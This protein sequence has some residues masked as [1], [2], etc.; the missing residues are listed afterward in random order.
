MTAGAR[1]IAGRFVYSPIDDFP[2]ARVQVGAVL[3]RFSNRIA[4]KLVFVYH[5]VG[6]DRSLSG[7]LAIAPR[8]CYRSQRHCADGQ[9]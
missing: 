9:G 6:A 2:V 1:S 7:A 5:F 3:Y 4:E 8:R